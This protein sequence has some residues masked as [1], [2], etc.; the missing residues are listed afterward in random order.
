MYETTMDTLAASG[1]EHYEIYNYAMPS[2][3]CQ[4]NL[5]YWANEAYFGFGMGAARYVNGR[6]EVNTRSLQGYIQRVLSGEP[7]TFQS[8]ELPPQERARETMAVQL[9]R[10]EGIDRV[11]FQQQTGHD[12][13]VLAGPA[14]AHHVEQELLADDG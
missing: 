5:V 7:A 2:R 11:A 4:H 8:E 1:Y 13:D 3:R 12:L 6:R 10:R 9:R 14:I